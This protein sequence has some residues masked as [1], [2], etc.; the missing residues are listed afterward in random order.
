MGLGVYEYLLVDYFHGLGD[1][2]RDHDRSPIFVF[3]PILMLVQLGFG[4]ILR[5]ETIGFLVDSSM[6]LPEMV[7]RPGY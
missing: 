1:L 5:L 6:M 4:R 7:L 3:P 2:R